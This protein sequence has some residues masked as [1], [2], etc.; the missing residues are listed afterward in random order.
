MIHLL[1][2]PTAFG[3]DPIREPNSKEQHKAYRTESCQV[4]G[5]SITFGAYKRA[6]ILFH[7]LES[8]VAMPSVD[9][10]VMNQ[11]SSKNALQNQERLLLLPT[12]TR[13][14]R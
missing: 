2:N 6:R 1:R 12:S 4:C 5:I 10:L 8:L 14:Q 13:N 11:P 7:R 3:K 9:N